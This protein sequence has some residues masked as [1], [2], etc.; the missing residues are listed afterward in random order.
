MVV[1]VFEMSV[2][3]TSFGLRDDSESQIRRTMAESRVLYDSRREVAITWD[4]L[5]M[6]VSEKQQVHLFSK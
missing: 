2:V 4:N 1:L 3:I 5:Q 6:E